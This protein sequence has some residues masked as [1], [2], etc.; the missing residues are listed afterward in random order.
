VTKGANIAAQRTSE[1]GGGNSLEKNLFITAP[2]QGNL[3]NWDLTSGIEKKKVSRKPA[4]EGW[5][6]VDEPQEILTYMV[7]TE[8][9]KGLQRVRAEIASKKKIHTRGSGGVG[10]PVLVGEAKRSGGGLIKER[11]SGGKKS[12]SAAGDQAGDEIDS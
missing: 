8:K 7:R 10:G 12:G 3:P 4:E 11:E 9:R 5:R 2:L 6:E 1:K